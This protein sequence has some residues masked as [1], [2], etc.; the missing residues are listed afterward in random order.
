MAQNNHRFIVAAVGLLVV[1]VLLV[2]ASPVHAADGS[3]NQTTSTQTDQ[4][5]TCEGEPQFA[6]LSIT[7]PRDEITTE[8][9]GLIEANFRVDENVPENCTVVVDL[10]FSFS[11]SGFQF[12]GGS[13]WEQS[14]SDILATEFEMSSGEIR[15]I[16]A[17]ISANGADIGD[18][19]TVVADYEVWYEGDRDNSRQ[20][21]GIRQSFTVE[22]S[23]SDGSQTGPSTSTAD[24]SGE[25]N[26][27][28]DTLLNEDD[29]DG[30]TIAEAIA[31][32]FVV[33]LLGG[34]VV[35]IGG[36]LAW[37]GPTIIGISS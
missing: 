10:Q 19:L 17:E 4:T 22:E 23:S 36:V 1:G 30:V 11:Q 24:N 26:E 34:G 33:V 8:R 27:G 28:T 31:N 15:S 9:A 21:S 14:A 16:D 32:N 2:G 6:R 12:E 29:D 25:Q 18:E 20:V 3:T 7:S 37:K 35:L 5:T 13:N